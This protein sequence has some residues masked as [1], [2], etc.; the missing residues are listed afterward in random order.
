MTYPVQG[1]TPQQVAYLNQ[2]NQQQGIQ[3][4]QIP[5][6]QQAP[7]IDPAALQ[8][9]VASVMTQNHLLPPA[10]QPVQQ[11]AQ[12]QPPKKQKAP[13]WLHILFTVKSILLDPLD[14]NDRAKLEN[15]ISD[16]LLGNEGDVPK[17]MNQ[18]QD[19]AA[20]FLK[21]PDGK[22]VVQLFVSGFLKFTE[23]KKRNESD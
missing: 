10:Q 6:Y 7:Q 18:Y 11:Q 17:T 16:A 3:P 13:D 20:A 4:P 2:L 12:Q 21:S 8:S 23:P 19:A 22:E 1:L 5:Q 14:A 9:A 15:Q